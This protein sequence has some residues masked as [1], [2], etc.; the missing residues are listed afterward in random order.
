M[1]SDDPVI[2]QQ[3]VAEY[4]RRLEQDSEVSLWPGDADV[5]PYPKQTIKSAIRT[6]VQTLESTGQLT[7][8]LR[9]FL[10][11]AYV[12][13]A[14]YVA[15]DLARLMAEFQRA[16]TDLAADRRLTSEKTAGE[17]WQTVSG[18][19]RLVGEVARA[20]ASEA[21]ALRAEFR[22]FVSNQGRA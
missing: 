10:E 7:G 14:D 1:S 5:L 9:E 20:I 3:I 13:L 6:S 19:S 22:G 2:A 12:A 15:A 8:D 18:S 21:D 4:A 17:A 16:G 11:T